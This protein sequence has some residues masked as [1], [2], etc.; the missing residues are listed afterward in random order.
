VENNFGYN[1]KKCG[2]KFENVEGM[3]K[4]GNGGEGHEGKVRKGKENGG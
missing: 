4:F 3:S 2:E 1:D